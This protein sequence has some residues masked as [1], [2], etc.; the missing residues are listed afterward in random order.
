MEVNPYQSPESPPE[1]KK[2]RNLITATLLGLAAIPLAGVAAGTT[3]LG[4]VNTLGLVS[5]GIATVVL[6]AVLATIRVVLVFLNPSVGEPN[7]GGA[8]KGLLL[9]SFAALPIGFVLGTVAVLEN[10]HPR[11]GV[12]AS[13]LQIASGVI[14]F[15]I[16]AIGA[17]IGL[18][19]KNEDQSP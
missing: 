4:T 16:W 14:P 13:L 7:Y 1:Q 17:W 18:H 8:I 19:W 10:A 2:R 12:T 3:C 6:V 15:C 9:A 5:F 11:D